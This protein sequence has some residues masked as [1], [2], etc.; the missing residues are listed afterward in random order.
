ML[1]GSVGSSVRTAD[2]IALVTAAP[3]GPYWDAIA[4]GA[5]DAA[6]RYNVRLTLLRPAADE[7][8]QSEAIRGLMDKGF[9]GVGVSP[10]EPVV[11][12]E[13]ELAVVVASLVGVLDDERRVQ[14]AVELRSDVWM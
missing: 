14:A 4:Q 3:G 13:D 1:S 5:Q 11:D 8:S 9:D 12:D 2:R 7:P 6:D 10:A